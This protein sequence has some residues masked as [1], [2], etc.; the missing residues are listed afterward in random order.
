MPIPS[1]CG[2]PHAY[3]L[4]PGT[5]ACTPHEV[6]QRFVYNKVRNKVWRYFLFSLE[7]M[8][9]L[10][11]VVPEVLIDGSFVTGRE[12]PG[13]VDAVCHIPPVD[14]QQMLAASPDEDPLLF[15]LK[16]PDQARRL[17]GVHMFVVPT[18]Q[19]FDYF[20]HGFA[21]GFG[22]K[23]LRPPDSVRDPAGLVVPAEKGLISVNF[24]GFF[25]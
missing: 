8:H 5:H 23:G 15:L 9:D 21:K 7:R 13:D 24:T 18:S 22:G 14:L 3:W 17:F 10:G 12:E 11:L 16:Q 20:R 19:N 1:F 2:S 6:T 25:S 4:P